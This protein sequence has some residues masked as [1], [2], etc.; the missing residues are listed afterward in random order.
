MRRLKKTR[1]CEIAR[2]AMRLWANGR[3]Q[4]CHQNCAAPMSNESPSEPYQTGDARC[5]LQ[6]GNATAE[7]A[8]AGVEMKNVKGRQG[9]A[10]RENSDEEWDN[11]KGQAGAVS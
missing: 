6:R 5:G 9:A 1:R 4:I 8:C 10:T 3:G 2:G 11:K 7:R